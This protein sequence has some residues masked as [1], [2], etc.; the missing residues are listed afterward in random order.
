MPCPAVFLSPACPTPVLILVHVARLC[1]DIGFVRFNSS[2]E[3]ATESLLHREA[4]SLQHKPSGL[5]SNTETTVKLV[6][7]DSI[8]AV[9]GQPHRRKPFVQAD[10]RVLEDRSDFH[11][12]LLSRM[13]VFALP[14]FGVFKKRHLLGATLR[15]DDAMRPAQRDQKFQTRVGVR[16]ISDCLKKRFRCVHMRRIHPCSG[17]S[18][19]LLPLQRLVR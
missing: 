1:A 14:Q 19:I 9:R 13:R 10:R 17:Q 5:L 8:F 4:D 7:T 15:T 6:R 11:R 18:S 12:K 3:F 16:E 2:G